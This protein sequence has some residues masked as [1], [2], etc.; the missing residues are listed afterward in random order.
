MPGGAPKLRPK[1]LEAIFTWWAQELGLIGPELMAHAEGV[2]LTVSSNLPGIMLFRRGGDLR[3]AALYPKLELIHE[4]IIGKTF[5]K[6]F[7]AAFWSRIPAL[8]GTAIG[9]A[10]LYY[11]DQIPTT[12]KATAPRG[13]TVRGLSPMDAKACADFA[14]ALG[15][16]ERDHCALE[17]GTRPTW[18][19]F[20]GKELLAIGGYDPWPGRIA[21]L[22]VAVH[23]EH[24]QKKLGQLVSQAAAKGAL[25]RRKIVQFRTLNTNEGAIGVAKALAFVPFAETLYIRP[26][27]T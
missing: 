3:I 21:H 17:L 27:G 2:T 15:E 11:L 1:T 9:P 12:W 18:G 10:T 19:V 6:I 14:N 5:P 8:C 16:S 22:S 20:K 25:T 13:F 24:R 26:P 7:D 23:P 4:A